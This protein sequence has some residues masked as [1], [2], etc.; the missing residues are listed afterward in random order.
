MVG[1]RRP[2]RRGGGGQRDPDAAGTGRGGPAAWLGQD[3]PHAPL[4]G[5]PAPRPTCASRLAPA[6]HRLSR[7]PDARCRLPGGG[8]R[9]GTRPR[10]RR[11]PSRTRCGRAS[12]GRSASDVAAAASQPPS[13]MPWGS[14]HRVLRVP[15]LQ[16]RSPLRHRVPAAARSPHRR[17]SGGCTLAGCDLLPWPGEPS[18][19]AGTLV[20]RVRLPLLLL[21]LRRRAAAER[22]PGRLAGDGAR[23]PA[24]EL[25]SAVPTRRAGGSRPGRREG[26]W[27]G[28]A[29]RCAEPMRVPRG[30]GFAGT[31]P[32]PGP[33][34]R[35]RPA[36][37]SGRAPNL[38]YD[39]RAGTRRQRLQHEPRGPHLL[40]WGRRAAFSR[41]FSHSSSRESR[42]HGTTRLP[43]PEGKFGPDLHLASSGAV[44]SGSLAP[45][46]LL[47]RPAVKSLAA[48]SPLSCT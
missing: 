38:G 9:R 17:R 28:E 6:R 37:A 43:L 35:A 20:R 3:A 1:A 15:S 4:R 44:A 41:F 46:L 14:P 8:R 36:P 40:W 29:R 23:G 5:R 39:G 2:D 22:A 11:L 27:L 10:R 30:R 26:R 21:L 48:P 31:R 7:R 45:T 19:S 42:F 34:V 32:A 25:A 13:P 33:C 24:S 18:A 16:A 47:L 12:L